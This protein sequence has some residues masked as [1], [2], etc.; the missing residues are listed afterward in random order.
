V[1]GTLVTENHPLMVLSLP[2]GERL[3]G[4]GL[5]TRSLSRDRIKVEEKARAGNL[6]QEQV[7]ICLGGS[8]RAGREK[9]Q[10]SPRGGGRETI[11]KKVIHQRGGKIGKPTKAQRGVERTIN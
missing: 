4:Q 7:A 8:D 3:V 2:S 6:G 11:R 5:N 1:K 10:R 9:S